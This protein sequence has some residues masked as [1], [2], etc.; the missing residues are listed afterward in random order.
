MIVDKKKQEQ[1]GAN[2]LR[3]IRKTADLI[4]VYESARIADQE[5]GISYKSISKACHESGKKAGGY[6][7]RFSIVSED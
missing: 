7:W 6:L 4:K 2:R 5:T 1:Q 3:N